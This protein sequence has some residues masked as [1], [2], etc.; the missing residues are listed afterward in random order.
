MNDSIIKL[1]TYFAKFVPR[2]A[3]TS[4]FIQPDR[5]RAAGYT[6]IETEIMSSPD[7]HVI[8]AIARYVV[9]VNE[10][11]VSERIKNLKGFALFVEYGKISVNHDSAD[12]IR[13]S[14]ALTVAHPFSDTNSDNLNEVLLMN[15]A[16]EILDSILRTMNNEQ[17]GLDFC[18][19]T[20][21]KWPAELHPVDPVAFYGCGGWSATFTN[22]YTLL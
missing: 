9:S 11:F 1:F 3:L 13:Q 17:H 14:L 6:E 21:L 19:Y 20:L 12:G 2:E 5:S 18:G 7:T 8:P 22:S 15:E 4:V 10:N 16:L